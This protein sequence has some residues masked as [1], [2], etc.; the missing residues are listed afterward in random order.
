MLKS[1]QFEANCPFKGK[2][3][4]RG[5][6]AL[7]PDAELRCRSL[8]TEWILHGAIGGDRRVPGDDLISKHWF[9]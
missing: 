3:K 8:I 5:F 2:G 4:L 6:A 1:L 7:K 9:N